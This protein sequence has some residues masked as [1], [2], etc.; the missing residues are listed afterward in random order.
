MKRILPRVLALLF[1]LAAAPLAAEEPSTLRALRGSILPLDD[2]RLGLEWANPS[3]LVTETAEAAEEEGT[4]APSRMAPALLCSREGECV[5]AIDVALMRKASSIM[6]QRWLSLDLLAGE[7]LLGFGAA[8]DLFGGGKDK[9]SKIPRLLL[10]LAMFSEFD[11]TE[12]LGTVSGDP[13]AEQ[14]EAEPAPA[15][16]RKYRLGLMLKMALK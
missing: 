9:S 1:L 7:D 3:S 8:I 12:L 14:Q 15:E 16:E 13:D 6:P 2:W 4:E 10:G 11:W 5:P